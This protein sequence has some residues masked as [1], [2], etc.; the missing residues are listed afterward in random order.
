[1]IFRAFLALLMAGASMAAQAAFDIDQ[2]MGDLARHRGGK[3]RFVE[4]RTLAMLDRPVQ[5]SGEM[6]YQPPDRLEKR[7]FKPYA[8]TVVLDKDILSVERDQRRMSIQ[9]AS[10]PEAQAFV[11]SVRSTLSGNRPALEKHYRLELSGSRQDWS[12][13]LLPVD[14]AVAALIRRIT[15]TGQGN[16]VRRIE[17][18]QAD[19]DRSELSIEPVSE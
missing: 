10:R 13:V 12:L 14:T 15:V 9:V 19:G 3:A 2:L 17:Y 7:T 5:S 11:E 18:L 6:S 4:T 16:Q 1:M 8:E